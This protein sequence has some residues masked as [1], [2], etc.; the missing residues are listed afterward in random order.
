MSEPGALREPFA[1]L[2]RQRETQRLGMLVFLASEAMLFAG[3][4]GAA[5]ALRLL[6]PADYVA[7]SQGLHLWFGTANTALLLTSSAAAALAVERARQGRGR[8]AA[9]LLGTAALLGAAFL[10]VKFA[11]YAAEYREGLIPMLAPG[12][13]HGAGET[14]FMTFYFFATALHAL[15][16]LAGIVILAA[17][18]LS[19]AARRDRTATAIG[20]AALY[21]HL[22]DVIWIFLFPTLYLAR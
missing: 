20:N 6:H 1:D 15:H 22:V 10:A 8:S 18:A 14:L 17:M 16:V 19:P 9:A 4:F 13:L 5:L 7:A 3:L 21:W 12:G 11:E 2:G